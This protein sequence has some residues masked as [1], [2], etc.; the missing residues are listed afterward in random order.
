MRATLI[1]GC[2]CSL[3]PFADQAIERVWSAAVR[4]GI[5]RITTASSRTYSKPLY[6]I[7]PDRRLPAHCWTVIFFMVH[8]PNGLCVSPTMLQSAPILSTR[9]PKAQKPAPDPAHG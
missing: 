5:A 9:S 4:K 2:A 7:S 3:K 1:A 6:M 8:M